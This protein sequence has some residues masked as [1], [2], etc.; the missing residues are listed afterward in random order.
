[1]PITLAKIAANTASV[2]FAV[3][4]D[5]INITYYPGR[6]TEKT[7]SI[8][9]AFA[10]MDESSMTSGFEAFN[11]MLASLIQSWDV[12]EDDAQTQMFPIDGA[13]FPEL[14]FGFRIEAMGA[15]MSDIRPETVA[16]QKTPNS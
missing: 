4:E 5:T 11:A 2:S 12:F 15:I 9:N 3:A 8:M 6:V 16:P 10:S 14:P 13:R 7:I 1:M